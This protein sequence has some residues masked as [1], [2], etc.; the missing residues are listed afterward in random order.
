[1]GCRSAATSEP[2]P[3]SERGPYPLDQLAGDLA[4]ALGR[5]R[6]VHACYWD[7]EWRREHRG[8]GRY[9]EHH[10][11]EAVQGYLDLYDAARSAD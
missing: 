7:Q 2:Q 8:S 3:G 5:L 9:P 11:W 10:L 4:V 1:M 6:A